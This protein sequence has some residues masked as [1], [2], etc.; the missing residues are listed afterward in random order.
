M[1]KN[2]YNDK[3]SSIKKLLEK[4]ALYIHERNFKILATEVYKVSNN[5]SPPHERKF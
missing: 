2:I 5:V 1:P 4:T 3:Q